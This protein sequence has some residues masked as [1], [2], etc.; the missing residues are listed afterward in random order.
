MDAKHFAVLQHETKG[1]WRS[2][3]WLSQRMRIPMTHL[4]F[5]LS[6]D[7]V[8]ADGI[9]HRR[10]LYSVDET[11]DRL[12]EAIEAVGAKIFTVIDQGAEAEDVML[13]LRDTVLMIFGDTAL[14]TQVMDAAPLSAL[15]LPLKILIWVDDHGDV[16][17]S[18]L[19]AEWLV[20][21]YELPSEL[22][23]LLLAPEVLTSRVASE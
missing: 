16:W 21:R 14:G 17:M 22:M 6:R 19:A 8:L 13:R 12:S 2:Y 3:Q 20:Q 5:T 18:Y 10:S 11:L 7:L 9:R 15:D 1:S 4:P 23:Q